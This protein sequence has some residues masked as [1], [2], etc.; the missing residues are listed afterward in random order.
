MIEFTDNKTSSSSTTI[1]TIGD[2]HFRK[3]AWNVL[4]IAIPNLFQKIKQLNPDYIVILGDVLHDQ[5]Y[6]KSVLVMNRAI[7]MIRNISKI[8]PVYV[9][10]GNHDMINE[11]QFLT[12]NH[13]MYCLKDIPNIHI[14]DKGMVVNTPSGKVVMVPYVPKNRFIEA[15][16]IIDDRWQEARLILAHQDFF[17]GCF[18]SGVMCEDGD[19]WEKTYPMVVTGHYHDKQL[20]QPNLYYT[21]SLYCVS[22]G[23]RK[24]KSIALCEIQNKKITIEEHTLN[25]PRNIN[26]NVNIDDMEKFE[27]P[28][29]K[30]DNIR[31]VINATSDEISKF[32]KTKKYNEIVKQGI[33]I[34]VIHKKEKIRVVNSEFHDFKTTLLQLVEKNAEMKALYDELF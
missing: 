9:L 25:V 21:G 33:K 26:I 10:V 4:D 17:G 23:D 2:P 7:E 29:T 11:A 32:K 31:L 34:K 8:Q 24:E 18:E 16:N 22:A 30:H 14:V 15:L 28:Q 12:E 20:V 1:L 19:K 5:S 3:E 13:W 27:I 6:I